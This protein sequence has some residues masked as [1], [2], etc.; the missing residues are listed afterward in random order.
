MARERTS[1]PAE[2]RANVTS[3]GGTTAAAIAALDNAETA[4]ILRRALSAARDRAQALATE[5]GQ[6]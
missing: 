6:S 5:F 4:A 2:L 3:P 1:T